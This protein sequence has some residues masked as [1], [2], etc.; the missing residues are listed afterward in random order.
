MKRNVR[1]HFTNLVL[2]SKPMS[3]KISYFLKATIYRSPNLLIHYQIFN[4]NITKNVLN[5]LFIH[6]QIKCLITKLIRFATNKKH[7]QSPN[8]IFCHQIDF[9]NNK[10]IFNYQI[11]FVLLSP[12][13]KVLVLSSR[14]GDPAWL[15]WPTIRCHRWQNRRKKEA[16]LAF[17][18]TVSSQM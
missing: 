8:L 17:K 16:W 13:R 6:H 14:S 3:L 7:F 10:L 1:E 9:H 18:G 15:H 2:G 11:E 4:F 5:H 12:Q